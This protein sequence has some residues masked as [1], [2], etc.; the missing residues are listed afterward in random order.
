M[1]DERETAYEDMGYGA[2]PADLANETESPGH[3]RVREA[4]HATM[5]SYSPPTFATEAKCQAHPA[6]CRN[7]VAV[8]EEAMGMFET[9]NRQLAKRGEGPLDLDACFPCDACRVKRSEVAVDKSAARREK[10]TEAIRYLKNIPL[11]DVNAA[12][13]L[14]T[15]GKGAPLRTGETVIKAMER[16][17]WLAKVMGGGYVGDLVNALREKARSGGKKPRK[18]EI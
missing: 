13:D 15:T 11:D 7:I 6:G 14:T 12:Y 5:P 9:F 8:T 3:A 10:T 2:M 4:R 18:E 16:M 17:A 1:S